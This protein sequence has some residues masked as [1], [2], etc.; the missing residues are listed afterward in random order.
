MWLN[1]LSTMLISK[2]CFYAL[3]ILLSLYRTDARRVPVGPNPGKSPESPPSKETDPDPV[4]SM[5]PYLSHDVYQAHG[6]IL[7]GHGLGQSLE[8]PPSS[9][10]AYEVQRRVPTGP[11]PRQSPRS[12]P[13][14][15]ETQSTR[16]VPS[17]PD[18]VESSDRPSSNN[19]YQV[20]R[21]VPTGPNPR[22]S[23]ESPPFKD[24]A[25]TNALTV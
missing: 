21:L 4:E 1:L 24:V 8:S 12:P 23:P 2:G 6:N 18:P 15:N 16:H 10:A 9:D 7:T 3:L 14:E 17:C 13:L 20:Q 11:D 5:G 19:A 25:Q 22:Q